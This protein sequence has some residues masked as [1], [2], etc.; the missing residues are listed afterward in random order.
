MAEA[1]LEETPVAE[2]GLEDLMSSF[3]KHEKKILLCLDKYSCP[4][5]SVMLGHC[6]ASGALL[7]EDHWRVLVSSNSTTDNATPGNSSPLVFSPPATIRWEGVVIAAD[8]IR[9]VGIEGRTFSH[10]ISEELLNKLRRILVA[11]SPRSPPIVVTR[12]L[13][14]A[15]L[16]CSYSH[17][18]STVHLSLAHLSWDSVYEYTLWPSEKYAVLPCTTA[19]PHISSIGDGVPRLHV[20]FTG[21]V[22]TCSTDYNLI[23]K[24]R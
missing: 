24:D 3:T 7:T 19:A 21:S 23:C 18:S 5:Q 4:L 22:D 1:G 6:N 16:K 2:A 12:L 15:M 8:V 10:F 20:S 9:G 14:T 17:R 13:T 11:V